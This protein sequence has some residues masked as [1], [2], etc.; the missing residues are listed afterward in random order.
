[1]APPIKDASKVII[2]RIFSSTISNTFLGS[3]IE[4]KLNFSMI[5]FLYHN[6]EEIPEY[7]YY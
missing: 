6:T 1:M 3:K 7:Y 4:Q 5:S 2:Y